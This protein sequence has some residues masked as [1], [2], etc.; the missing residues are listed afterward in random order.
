[1]TMRAFIFGAGYSG[2]AIGRAV[3]AGGGIAS[4]TTRSHEKASALRGEGIEPFI[5]DGETLP[6]EIEAALAGAT[7]LVMS[8]APDRSAQDA[9]EGFD[10]VLALLRKTI[11]G[12]MPALRWIGYLSTVGVYGNHDG[13]WVTEETPCNPVSHRSRVRLDAEREWSALGEE[14]SV[15]VAVLR[16]SGIYGPGRN[17]LVNLD[18]GTARRIVKRG[19]VFNRIHVDDIAEAAMFLTGKETGGVFNV[20]DDEPAPPEDVVA[21]AAS[22]KG[23]PPPPEVAFEE[24]DMTPMAR[25]F[26]GESKRVSNAR[27]RQAGYRFRFPDYRIALD[28]MWQA[29][30]WR[31]FPDPGAG[32]D[33]PS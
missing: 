19:Q 25:S 9:M 22:L 14:A 21:Y 26:Y 31:G 23:V 18:K 3:I 24:A 10:P 8:I 5:F 15:P 13:A 11:T 20:T 17:A 28:H 2:R 29:G 12:Q 27:L 4:G 30:T 7:H 16:L 33:N 32:S 6:E 1:M